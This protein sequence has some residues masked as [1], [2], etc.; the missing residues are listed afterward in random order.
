[1]VVAWM[2]VG[3]VH[4]VMNT[5][6]MSI[7]GHTIDYGPYG[8]LEG[9]DP[10]WT[11]NTTDFSMRRYCYGRQPRVAMWN[12]FCFANAIYPLV[13]SPEPLKEALEDVEQCLERA[14]QEMMGAKLGLSW[15]AGD[16]ALVS[17]LEEVLQLSETDMTLF[18]RGLSRVPSAQEASDQ[19]LLEP[20]QAAVYV[21][22]AW[23]KTARGPVLD[24]LRR[25]T[26]RV[27]GAGL[28][29]AARRRS[30]NRVNPKYV[31]RNY[32]AQVAI[33]GAEEGDPRKLLELLDVMREPYGEQPERE[34]YAAKRP[35]WARDRPGCSTLSCSS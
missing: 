1:M 23:D 9:Y 22:D 15:S 3:F 12:L 7:L 27:R 4:G 10:N 24:W 29:D 17:T 34:N 32:L 21:S 13:G 30:M 5:D 20:I 11:P 33:D 16:E 14:Q 6:N 31:L 8:W 18:Y 35:E 28:S 2:R 26:A 25:Y 19:E